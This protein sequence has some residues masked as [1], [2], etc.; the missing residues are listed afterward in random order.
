[1]VLYYLGPAVLGANDDW[2]GAG[3]LAAAF[4]RVGAFA[5]AAP[6][7]K[8][9]A[10]LR[11]AGDALVGG[12]YSVHVTGAEGTAG[13]VLVELYDATPAEAITSTTPRLIN[14]SVL[15]SIS[16]GG[17]L[18][19]G[20]V[21]DGAASKQVLIRAVGPT[22]RSAP[23]NVSDAMADPRVELFRGSIAV[24]SN[25][26]WGGGAD[27]AAVFART[28]AFALP[29]ASRDAALLVALPPGAYTAQVTGVGGASGRVIVEVYEVP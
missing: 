25:D 15:H 17:L 12:G 20:F 6:T 21:L 2:G 11:E 1:M 24:G 28:G 23:F 19:A 5:Y 4:A 29:A 9:A 18:T 10:L 7:S 14:V 22:L 16:A 8:D 13:A 3:G 26:N 27:L